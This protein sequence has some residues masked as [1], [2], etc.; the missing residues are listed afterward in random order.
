MV[1][2]SICKIR[3]R[4]H[5]EPLAIYSSKDWNGESVALALLD[6]FKGSRRPNR[7]R[8]DMEQE[9]R[10]RKVQTVFKE[11]SIAIFIQGTKWNQAYRNEQSKPWNLES[12]NTWDINKTIDTST[13]YR[14]LQIAIIRLIIERLKQNLLTLPTEMKKVS[15]YLH[16]SQNLIANNLKRGD[17]GLKVEITWG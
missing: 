5:P 12:Q 6:I 1:Y 13:N 11:N 14:V 17:L 3:F 7:V 15:G 16:A 9:F 8:S 10:S 4:V 2:T